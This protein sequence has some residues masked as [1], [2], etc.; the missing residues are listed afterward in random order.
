M[1]T[2]AQQA[3]MEQARDILRDILQPGDTVYT[4]L[5]QVAANGMSRHI[6]VVIPRKRENGSLYIRNIT[7]VVARANGHRI[8][9]KTDAIVIG[10]AGMDMGFWLIYSLSSALYPN[11][12]KCSGKGKCRS[13]DHS[14]DYGTFSRQYD[15]EHPDEYA[16]SNRTPVQ[17]SAY[18]SARQ[19]W[20]SEQIAK[21]Y[22][23]TR[24]HSDGGY[25]LSQS[26]I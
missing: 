19:A 21:S 15:Q 6:E 26:W 18:V 25:T 4:S 8:S 11:G 22:S 2:K 3:D 12:A 20:I 7:G 24:V 13:N 10:G 16:G 23:K 5:R 1:T 9:P 17:S 14:N